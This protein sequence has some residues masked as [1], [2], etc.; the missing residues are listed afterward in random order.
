MIYGADLDDDWTDE[1]VWRKV[2]PSLSVTVPIEKVRVACEQAKQN[3][4]EEN[5]FRQLRL[6]QWVKQ[7]V[8]WMPMHVWNQNNTPVDLAELE[9]RV[10]YGGLD[11]ASTTDITA[12]VLVF[13]PYGDDDKYTVAPWFWI[14]EDNLK[15]RVARDHVPY[16]LWHKQGYLETT[17]GNVVR[18]DH[19]EHDIE[20]LGL[21]FNIREIAYDRWG[22]VQMSQTSK[23]SASLS[24]PSGKDSKTCPH[25]ARNSSAVSPLCSQSKAQSNDAMIPPLASAS[26]AAASP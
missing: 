15:L 26:A 19:I 10:C 13:P 24:S 3:P 1:K 22:A 20:Q 11:L 5:T 16:D 12:F 6:N 25:Q 14:P 4:V 8:R 9:G 21:R 17:E 23:A 18:Y 7:S 2:N